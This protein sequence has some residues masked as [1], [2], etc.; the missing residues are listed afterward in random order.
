MIFTISIAMSIFAVVVVIIIIIVT[1]S[2]QAGVADA[3]THDDDGDD[4]V[5]MVL[6]MAVFSIGMTCTWHVSWQPSS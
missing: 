4:H 3:R 2:V 5:E 6:I 1:R